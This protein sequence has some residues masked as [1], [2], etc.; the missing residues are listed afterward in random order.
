MDAFEQLPASARNRP[1]LARIDYAADDLAALLARLGQRLPDALPG[2]HAPPA[3]LGVTSDATGG[4]T[5]G[6]GVALLAELFSRVLATLNL[7]ADQRANESYL[8]TATLQRS[9]IDLCALIDVR[10]GAGASANTLQAFTLKPGTAGVLAA[11]FKLAATGLDGRDLVYETLAALDAHVSRNA[12]HLVGWNRSARRLLLRST[13]MALQDNDATLDAVYGGLKAGLPIVFDAGATLAAAP[14]VASDEAGGATRIRW[15]PGAAG[16][17]SDLPI[18]DL[19]LLAKP[20]QTLRLD[21]ADAADAIALGQARL[22]LVD[23]AHF[24]VGTAV[25][26]TSGALQMPALVIAR[27]TLPGPS[28]H[29]EIT[30]SRGVVAALRLSTVRVLAGTP[31]GDTTATLRAGSN[32]LQIDRSHTWPT[33]V[34]PDPGDLLMAADASGIELLT[35]AAVHAHS[36]VLAQPLL[37][38]LRPVAIA[39]D[40]IQ[41]VRYHRVRPTDPAAP[42]SALLP[43]LLQALPGVYSGA[44][45]VLA[46]DR[47]ADGLI[48]GTVVAWRDGSHCG[49]LRVTG[50]DSIDGKTVLRLQG[51]APGTLRVATLAVYGPFEHRMRIAGHDRSD[52][53]LAAGAAQL[54]IDGLPDGL[55]AGLDLVLS[56]GSSAEGARVTQVSRP[57]TPAGVTRIA[58]ARPLEHAYALADLVVHGNVA[59]VS[60]GASAPDEVLGSGDPGAAPQRWRLARTPLAW[61][62]D[63]AA[64]R[65]VAPALEIW[66]G[67]ERW[68]R[69]DTLAASGPLDRHYA[70]EIDEQDRASIVFGDGAHGAPAPSGRNNIV[71]RYRSGRGAAANLAAGAIT[72]LPQP[73]PFLAATHNPMAATGGAERDT[74]ADTRRQAAHR[75][76]TLDRAVTL[77][78]H[79]E[80][81]LAY[82]GIAKARADRERVGRGAAARPLIVVT[83]AATG[84]NRLS[85]PMQEALLA[86]L[87]ARSVQ[88]QQVRVRSHRPWPVRLSL[89]VTLLPGWSRAVVQRT[90]LARF[91]S[92][93]PDAFFHFDRR[94]LGA[95]IALSEVYAQAE[96]SDG[97]DHALATLF[98]AEADEAAVAARSDPAA[99]ADRIDVPA[100]AVAS[101][102]A[103]LAAGIGRLS[104]TLAGGL[105]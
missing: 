5:G 71:A 100:D 74:P 93:A 84:G 43:L 1:A 23:A 32:T 38:A 85:M 64:P 82:A 18:A 22:A 61:L 14:L 95:D 15:A 44:D 58:L 50:A 34:L 20:K 77:A 94:D 47:A 70:V 79:A 105:P 16:I 7:Y 55:V 45:T 72:R 101:G 104:L 91:G 57:Q 73:A 17:S 9:L 53:T 42:Q 31:C 63:P 10:P 92:T 37:R 98:H 99:V 54:D 13:A 41:R 4:A 27:S 103:A 97:V 24:A 19:T 11:G 51:H 26:L 68:T 62:P 83:C 2:W 59:P 56:D 67:A 87:C 35:V 25:L 33:S 39:G 96:A 89:Q 28:P 88:P 49:A 80:L 21:G 66:I 6:D 52:A 69:V 102:G 65:G 3:G 48:P 40:A 75:V 30:L 81:A 12:L 76:R 36:I 86:T 90:L 8:R 29:G 78:D 60:H 46:L